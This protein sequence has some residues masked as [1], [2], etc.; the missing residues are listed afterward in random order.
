MRLLIEDGDHVIEALLLTRSEPI[1]EKTR[2]SASS[3]FEK[4]LR[5]FRRPEV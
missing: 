3:P 4:S 5:L 1:P 2:T